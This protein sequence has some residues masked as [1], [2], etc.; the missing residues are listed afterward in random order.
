MHAVQ[1]LMRQLRVMLTVF[2][3]YLLDVVNICG[4]VTDRA[5]KHEDAG[6]IFLKE[7]HY[8]AKN[9]KIN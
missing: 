1:S 3:L 9:D 2:W 5:E 7:K 6:G 4:G 8:L